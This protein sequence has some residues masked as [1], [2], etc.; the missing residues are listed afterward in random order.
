MTPAS[1]RDFGN[2]L[3]PAAVDAART[4]GIPPQFMVAQAALETGWGKSE[5]RHAD[6]SPSYNIFG[7]KAGRNWAGPVVEAN[8]TEYVDGV[9]QKQL[10]K[11][12]AYGSYAE[13]FHDYA[14]LLANSPRYAGVVGTQDPVSF[15]RGLQRGGFATDPMYA[16]KLERIIAGP[17][18]RVALAG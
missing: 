3:W 6:G 10:E 13:A 17:N 15:A 8:T 18:L 2:K 7:I 5:I 4:T 11:F 1:V 14:S 12:R 16:A 9:S